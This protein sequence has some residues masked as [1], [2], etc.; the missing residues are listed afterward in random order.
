MP[1]ID[2]M[3]GLEP[4]QDPVVTQTITRPYTTI[5]AVV[6]LGGVGAAAAPSSDPAA[7]TPVVPSSPQ[8][9]SSSSSSSSSSLPVT[10]TGSSGLTPD[11]L[12]AILGSIFG[13]LVLAGLLWCACSPR[14][15]PRPGG[16]RRRRLRSTETSEADLDAERDRLRFRQEHARMMHFAMP[17]RPGPVLVPPPA[18]FPPT[19][20]TPAYRQSSYPQ[21]RD[22]RLYP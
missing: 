12:G 9:S 7:T 8:G 6:T 21:I 2:P 4:R 20:P 14:M 5:T 22:V 3:R 13:V 10:P 19:R 16:G 15:R 1:L 18:R 11:Q 17:P